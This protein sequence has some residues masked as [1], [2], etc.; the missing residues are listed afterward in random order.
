MASLLYDDDDDNDNDNDND[1]E[2]Y[3]GRATELFHLFLI[4]YCRSKGQA[5]RA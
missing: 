4:R 5:P 2:S 3:R 1:N